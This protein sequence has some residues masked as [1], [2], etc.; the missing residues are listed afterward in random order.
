VC[1]PQGLG[2]VDA[3][4]FL[5]KHGASVAQAGKGGLTP[6]HSAVLGGELQ[7]AALLLKHKPRQGST[8]LDVNAL[9]SSDQTV[10]C[11]VGTAM[12]CRLETAAAT[13]K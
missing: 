6:L 1:I 5:V 8:P 4:E 2:M 10:P 13:R 7:A 12:N 3:A 9:T 11:Y